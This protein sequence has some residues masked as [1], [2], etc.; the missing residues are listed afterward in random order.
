MVDRRNISTMLRF[1]GKMCLSLIL[2]FLLLLGFAI[3]VLS[4]MALFGDDVSIVKVG[5]IFIIDVFV[6]FGVVTLIR[7][8]R[9]W[10]YI[11]PCVPMI[12]YII[13]VILNS[14]ILGMCGFSNE[15]RIALNDDLDIINVL[16][17]CGATTSYT[18]IVYIVPKN[19]VLKEKRSK[20]FD[21]KYKV[22]SAYRCYSDDL[23][24]QVLN[25]NQV[26]VKTQCYEF[27]E[28]KPRFVT[29]HHNVLVVHNKK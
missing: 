29:K 2:A 1:C 8:Q 6:L 12:C 9:L 13:F 19:T 26:V 10:W 28:H 16:H 24:I 7:R 11:L 25:S 5:I 15:K 4:L 18:N 23:Q 27:L 22:F 20:R 21:K 14:F 17:D 3:I